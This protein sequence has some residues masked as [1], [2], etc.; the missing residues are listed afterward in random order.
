MTVLS[1]AEREAMERE[2]AFYVRAARPITF[3]RGFLAARGFYGPERVAEL[4]RERD[5]LADVARSALAEHGVVEG[6]GGTW[7]TPPSC[8][9]SDE[10]DDYA[11]NLATALKR[12]IEETFQFGD[13]GWGVAGRAE[14]R[15]CVLREALENPSRELLRRMWEDGYEL[16]KPDGCKALTWG[17]RAAAILLKAAVALAVSPEQPERQHCTVEGDVL[18]TGDD[19]SAPESSL[20][21]QTESKDSRPAMRFDEVVLDRGEF[22]QGRRAQ[23]FALFVAALGRPMGS[24]QRQRITL[25]RLIE[26]ANEALG[27]SDREDPNG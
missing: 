15:E 23:G 25:E 13:E 22:E 11:D 17:E 5:T 14:Q 26:K 16:R 3:E 2:R 6:E 4:E 10:G 7:H 24:K 19:N 8:A 18:G 27:S 20:P 12:L 21:E 9:P 1:T